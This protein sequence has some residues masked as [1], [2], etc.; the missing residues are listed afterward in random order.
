MP[1]S[2][3]A[4]QN[5]QWHLKLY[6]K[7]TEEWLAA[8][9]RCLS[10]R[11]KTCGSKIARR[12]YLRTFEAF[13]KHDQ[14][15]FLVLTLH[16]TKFQE[17]KLSNQF[18]Y[19]VIN[20]NFAKLRKRI[21]RE[22]GRFEFVRV[23]ERTPS[24]SFPHVN[25]VFH[26]P[27]LFKQFDSD[28]KITKWN[29]RWLTKHAKQ[30]GFGVNHK[31]RFCENKQI[32]ANYLAKTGLFTTV[33]KEVSKQTQVPFDAPSHFRRLGATRGLLPSINQKLSSDWTGLLIKSPIPESY[34]S[35]GTW[36]PDDVIPVTPGGKYYGKEANA[37]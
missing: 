7:K 2:V 10:W 9:F 30:S 6:N 33:A 37:G 36:W 21:E 14:W 1:R 27:E 26:C 22:Y 32:T 20:K 31:I 16:V 13:Q 35:D 5:N 23:V 34:K 17:K 29:K 4:C 11:C 19:K 15:A 28:E 24:N 12:D 3:E 8:P 25:V 18:A